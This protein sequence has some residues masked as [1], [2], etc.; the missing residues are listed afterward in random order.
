MEDVGHFISIRLISSALVLVILAGML[1][2][3]TGEIRTAIKKA[4]K[5][6]FDFSL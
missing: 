1:Y 4:I 3:L 6:F 5:D 2:P